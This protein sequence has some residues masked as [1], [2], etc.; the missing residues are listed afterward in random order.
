MVSSPLRLAAQYAPAGGVD[1]ALVAFSRCRSASGRCRIIASLVMAYRIL[2]YED[3]HIRLIGDIR[4]NCR[5]GCATLIKRSSDWRK[6]DLIFRV[7]WIMFSFES[8]M[9]LVGLSFASLV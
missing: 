2:M 7:R 3:S 9:Q 6:V 1:S 8:C 4:G 5:S